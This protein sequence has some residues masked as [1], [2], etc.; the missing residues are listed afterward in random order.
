MTSGHTTSG[1]AAEFQPRS[2]PSRVQNRKSSEGAYRVRF[3][4]ESRY[5]RAAPPL[6][7]CATSSA[8]ESGLDGTVRPI[9]QAIWRLMTSWNLV[10]CSTGKSAGLVR[11]YEFTQKVRPLRSKL[12]G[13]EIDARHIAARPPSASRSAGVIGIA[14]NRFVK[15]SRSDRSLSSSAKATYELSPGRSRISSPSHN[16]H[17][18]HI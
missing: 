1:I 14:V 5:G 16:Q 6:P 15:D 4:P 12:A 2:C 9:S 8:T 11:R 10:D 17:N 7:S 13:E 18:A 3:S